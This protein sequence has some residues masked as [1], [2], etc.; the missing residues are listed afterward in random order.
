[1]L[2]FQDIGPGVVSSSSNDLHT[3]MKVFCNAAVRWIIIQLCPLVVSFTRYSELSVE[4]R[5]FS[6]PAHILH[7]Y[8]VPLLAV[9]PSAF[10]RHL[11]HITVQDYYIHLLFTTRVDQTTRQINKQKRKEKLN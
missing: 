10:Y 4:T 3:S 2:C 6:F 1:M 11:R 9:T 5:K 7:Q 8:S